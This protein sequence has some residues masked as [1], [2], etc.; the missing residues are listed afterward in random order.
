MLFL[1]SRCLRSDAFEWQYVHESIEVQVDSAKEALETFYRGQKR[2]R[3]AKTALNDQSS[4]SHSIFNIRKYL[5]QIH[6]IEI[7]SEKTY[8]LNAY[9]GRNLA[10][11]IEFRIL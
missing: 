5:S 2:R 1:I 9:I 11:E 4:R 7:K 8:W 6:T 3:E 10:I